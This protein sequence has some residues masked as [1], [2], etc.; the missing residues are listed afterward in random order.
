MLWNMSYH[1]LKP[2]IKSE[3][4]LPMLET[5]GMTVLKGLGASTSI[6]NLAEKEEDIK[7]MTCN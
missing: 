5:M 1:K 4:E 3:E 2:K 6:N 7:N